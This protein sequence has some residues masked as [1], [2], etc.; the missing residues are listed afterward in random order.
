MLKH[1]KYAPLARF[2][3][4]F[5]N[6]AVFQKF[7]R[8]FFDQVAIDAKSVYTSTCSKKLR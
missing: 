4:Y 2:A 1:W 8:N 6:Q 7:E 3:L 5:Y